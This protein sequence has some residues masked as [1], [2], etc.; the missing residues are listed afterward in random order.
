MV[1]CTGVVRAVVA[2]EVYIAHF[3]FFN[4]FDFVGVVLYY[5]VDTLAEA[6]TEDFRRLFR[7]RRCL[8]G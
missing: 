4:A 7:D 5:R 1:V 8:G 2:Q 3:Q 6:I